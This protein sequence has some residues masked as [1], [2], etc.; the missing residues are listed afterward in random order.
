MEQVRA[1]LTPT[2]V[3]ETTNHFN[4]NKYRQVLVYDRG[5]VSADMHDARKRVAVLRYS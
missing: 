2:P 5:S 1:N 4:H 3:R